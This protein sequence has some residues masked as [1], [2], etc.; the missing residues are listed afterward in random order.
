MLIGQLA[1]ATGVSTDTIRYYE[2]I[3]LLPK[4]KTAR[5]KNNYREYTE[6]DVEILGLAKQ[7]KSLGMTLDSITGLTGQWMKG[8]TSCGPFRSAL[9]SKLPEL[10]E[11]LRLI[12]GK[13]AEVESTL[14][15]CSDACTIDSVT[16]SCLDSKGC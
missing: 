12:K 8:D 6:T 4:E 7:L 16:P 15:K 13:I 1:T 10:K 2:K 11:A 9:D 14:N 5:R 3:G